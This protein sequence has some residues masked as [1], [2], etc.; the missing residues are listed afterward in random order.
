MRISLSKQWKK[1]NWGQ[2]ESKT[3]HYWDYS[4]KNNQRCGNDHSKNTTIYEYGTYFNGMQQ[5]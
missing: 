4:N 1:K 3:Q 5:W 2:I